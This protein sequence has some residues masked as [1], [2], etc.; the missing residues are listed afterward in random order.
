[1]TGRSEETERRLTELLDEAERAG[2]VLLF[3]EADAVFA[4]RTQVQDS[5]DRYQ[6]TELDVLLDRLAQARQPVFVV[7]LRSPPTP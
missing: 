3:D 1:M 7:P 6:T 5:H 4:R 2:A